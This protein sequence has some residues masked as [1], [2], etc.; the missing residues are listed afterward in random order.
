MCLSSWHH[1]LQRHLLAIDACRISPTF[2]LPGEKSISRP[3]RNV[4]ETLAGI[5]KCCQM[6]NKR[7]RQFHV[8]R[9]YVLFRVEFAFVTLCC[10]AVE[11]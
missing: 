4:Y 5:V 2:R 10:N 6:S 7:R 1:T 9:M 3:R 11:L 8:A